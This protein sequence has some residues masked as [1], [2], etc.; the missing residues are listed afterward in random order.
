[1]NLLMAAIFAV[2]GA[3][4]NTTFVIGAVVRAS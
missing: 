3:P 1:M 4:V 2:H